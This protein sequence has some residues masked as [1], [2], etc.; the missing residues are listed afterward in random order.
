MPCPSCCSATQPRRNAVPS[1]TPARLCQPPLDPS[2][3]DE[4]RGTINTVD[5]LEVPFALPML[6]LPPTD[7]AF[8][9]ARA[10]EGV[11][12]R[13]VADVEREGLRRL[14]ARAGRAEG[15]GAGEVGVGV[16]GAAAHALSANVTRLL[17]CSVIHNQGRCTMYRRPRYY[18][19]TPWF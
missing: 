4:A 19:C 14:H 1:A 12:L 16:G 13:E 9:C 18:S 15:L 17:L 2:Q 6:L 3:T 10:G 11:V 8:G 7:L 5:T